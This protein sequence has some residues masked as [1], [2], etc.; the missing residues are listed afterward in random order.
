[1]LA[2]HEALQAASTALRRD[3]CGAWRITGTKGHIYTWGD[4]ESFL[5]YVKV[6]R[7]KKKWT[8]NKRNLAFC[9]VTQDGDDEGCLRLNGLPDEDQAAWIRATLG[10]RRR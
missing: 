6:G 1:M 3:E 10:I 7:S 4:R 2:M 9:T 8:Y 5:L